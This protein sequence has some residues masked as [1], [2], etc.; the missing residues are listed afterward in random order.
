ML[1]VPGLVVVKSHWAVWWRSQ[2]SVPPV[3]VAAPTQLSR[4]F[5]KLILIPYP[6]HINATAVARLQKL[7]FVFRVQCIIITSYRE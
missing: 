3:S 5:S 7:I 2:R 4:S 6:G 1:M